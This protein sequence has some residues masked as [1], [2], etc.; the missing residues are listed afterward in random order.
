MKII[1][2]I[3]FIFL[4]LILIQV[5]GASAAIVRQQSV[6]VYIRTDKSVF[7][8]NEAVELSMCIKNISGSKIFFRIY[9]KYRYSTFQPVVID[10]NARNAENTVPY[11][12]ENRNIRKGIKKTG[13]RKITLASGE[14]FVHSA[15]IKDFFNLRTDTQYR[16]RGFF[17]PNF[18]RPLKIR[19]ENEISF[20]IIKVKK[21]SKR[22]VSKH[23]PGRVSPSETVLLLLSAEKDK[24]WVNFQK[25]I[26]LNEYIRNYSDFIREYSVADN[27]QKIKIE[28]NFLNFLARDRS[29]YITDFK[30]LG[31]EISRN[32]IYS[33]V[34]AIVE[35]YGLRYTER[36]KYKY[37][38]KK[39]SKHG[40]IWLINGFDA[41]VLKGRKR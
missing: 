27:I 7:Y 19:S 6:E 11:K 15:N 4:L 33:V 26:K 35:R 24:N 39:Y 31:E 14:M 3:T 20:K 23:L 29:D 16:V 34:Y 18:I 40:N 9:D 25:Y 38:L 32:E 5:T 17:Y 1:K 28:K 41:T 22:I 12:L 10:M 21:D 37:K 30:I 13:F 2:K 36:Y 8:E